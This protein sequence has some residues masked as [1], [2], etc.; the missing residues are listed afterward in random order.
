M[1]GNDSWL[2]LVLLFAVF[3][4]LPQ[5]TKFI[6][7]QPEK[8][9]EKPKM[10]IAPADIAPTASRS[11]ACTVWEGIRYGVVIHTLRLASPTASRKASWVTL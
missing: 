1:H 8:K 9:E 11:A 7:V 6:K 4:L 5:L 10:T 2:T 3:V